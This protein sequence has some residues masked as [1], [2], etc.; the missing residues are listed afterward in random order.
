MSAGSR[1]PLIVLALSS[2][3]FL[4][5]SVHAQSSGAFGRADRDL[6][7]SPAPCLLPPT[8]ASEGGSVVTDSPIA[9]NPLNARDLL[10]GSVDGNCGGSALGFHLS[11]DDGSTWK[12]VAC[13]SGITKKHGHFVYYAADEPS[14]GYDRHGTAY[15]AGIYFATEGYGGFLAVQKSTDGVHWSKPV[16]AL[17]HSGDTYPF[18]TRLAVDTSPDSP[19]VNSLYVSGVMRLD[20]G[21]KRQVLVSHSTDGGATWRQAA[22]DP[23]QEY[24]QQDDFTRM[25]VGGDGTVYITWMR[26]RG[27]EGQI[28]NDDIANMM[29]SKSSD[30]GSTWGAPRL[31][32]TV[33]MNWELP[34]TGERVYNYP[35]IAVDN[36]NGPYAGNLYVVMNTWTGTYLR[37]QM[38]RSTDDGGTWSQPL[39]LA[40]KDANHDQF[41]PSIS[42][43]PAGLVGVNW[44]D[45]R[46]DPANI[47]YQ[48]FAAISNDGGKSF[49]TNW[50]L[51][52]AFSN[53]K[54]NGTGNNWMGDYT[55][56]TW[57]GDD[58]LIAAWMDSSN[59]IDMQEVVGGVR[60][61]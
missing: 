48:A 55:G 11:R 12:R 46:N 15:I 42:V 1:V 7:C 57:N 25:A 50:Q 19:W 54:N 4:F 34:N 17:S 45:R 16:I 41:F 22:V 36:S 18:Q 21:R 49:G 14:V 51:T 47:D 26:C 6:S 59:G 53:P 43:S 33:K 60:L 10:L 32:A 35:A 31:I 30:G 29:F 8:Q 39:A 28:C 23:A 5:A 40:S 52:T 9:S 61:K 27:S 56:N 13:M 58:V 44:Q 38:I 20:Q 3:A 24:P 2:A 37:V